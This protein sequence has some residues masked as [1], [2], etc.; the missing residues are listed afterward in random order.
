[1][2]FGP[3][4]IPMAS[5]APNVV[6]LEF[7]FFTKAY[8]DFVANLALGGGMETL[9]VPF[10][11]RIW[12]SCSLVNSTIAAWTGAPTNQRSAKDLGINR[13]FHGYSPLKPTLEHTTNI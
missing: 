13:Q 8:S 6:I 9:L 10:W 3:G 4:T 12:T 7:P 11:G 1:M 5:S 2:R